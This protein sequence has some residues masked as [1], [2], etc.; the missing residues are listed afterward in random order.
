MDPPS[1]GPYHLL[2]LFSLPHS[3][4]SA[5]LSGLIH[6]LGLMLHWSSDLW[7]QV[8]LLVVLLLVAAFA[9][10][11]ETAL[12][13]V[14]RLRVRHMAEED[15][16]GSRNLDQLLRD[17]N[18]FLT[19]ILILNMVT[20]IVASGVAVRLA[21]VV[22]GPQVSD[23]LVSLGFSVI[24]LIAAEIIPK[25][26][27]IRTAERTALRVAPIVAALARLLAPLVAFFRVVT[28]LAM[29]VFGVRSVPGPFVTDE[30]LVMLATLGEE[31]GVLREEER[32]R[33]EAVIE[34]EDI[35]AH[36]VMVP[37]VDITA[38][39]LGTPLATTI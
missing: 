29:R 14:E 39:A 2:S 15:V 23:I 9:S 25:S 26:L 5:P 36:E 11:S 28:N 10:G 7:G 17:P 24:V 33:I 22:F 31:Q 34:F 6:P 21:F 32:R 1:W 4:T 20:I 27:A 12:T 8:I 38:V 37:R 18:Q 19:A 30:Q 3:P 16:A 35:A 13:S